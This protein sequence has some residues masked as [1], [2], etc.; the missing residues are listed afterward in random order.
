MLAIGGWNHGATSFTDLA[1]SG[2]SMQHFAQETTLFSRQFVFDCRDIDWKY[3]VSAERGGA[4]S[5]KECFPI[6]LRIIWSAFDE[7]AAKSGR[8]CLL[9]LA[10]VS[11]GATII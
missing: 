7:E 3:S 10:I 5:D 1:A 2:V 9:L 8:P 4:N 6:L 11:A